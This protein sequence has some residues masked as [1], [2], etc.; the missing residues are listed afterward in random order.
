MLQVTNRTPFE[1]QLVPM[2]DQHG[3]DTA[4]TIVKATFALEPRFGVAE[5]QVP[6]T[7]ADEYYGPPLTTSIRAASDVSLVKP[8]TDVLLV[9]SAYAPNDFP[10]W[11]VDVSLRVGA[12][13][14]SVRVFGDRVWEADGSITSVAPFLS[15]PLVWERAFGGP[16]VTA[17][18]PSIEP[19]NP[20]GV[21]YRTGKSLRPAVGT[22]L[23]NI[24]DPAALIT[25]S[26]S[27]PVPAGFA[28]V[29][30]HWLPRRLYAGTYDE[31][32]QHSR[33]PYLPSD[34]DCRY[35]S[36]AAPSLCSAG[37]LRGGELVEAF[38]VSDQGPLRFLLPAVTLQTTYQ[39]GSTLEERAADLDTVIIEPDAKRLI[40]VWRSAFP[41][42]KKVLKVR[43]V[44]V[45]LSSGD[46]IVS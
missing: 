35:F 40:M 10:V 28:P 21:G 2:P 15:M 38:G 9:G 6:I 39:L 36:I 30:P 41:C 33:A 22:P 5:A 24:E 4:F 32:W 31:S 43:Q 19:R 45:Q 46:G 13:E 25:S 20:V 17:D 3:V 11:Q 29:A 42:D 1:A 14:K 7:F 23:P 12:L 16:D 8:G 26:R 27:T 37:Y 18:G 44:V 34:F